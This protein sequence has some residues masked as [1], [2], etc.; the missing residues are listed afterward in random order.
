MT[1]GVDA[2]V[3]LL[4]WGGRVLVVRKRCPSPSPWACD[5]ALPGGRLRRGEDPVHAALREAW[6][7]AW[8]HPSTVEVK[9]IH[10]VFETATGWV[11]VAVVRGEVA[12]PLDPRPRDPEVDAVVWIPLSM[13]GDA[14][15]VRHPVRGQVYGILLPGGLI[16]W[17]VTYRILRSIVHP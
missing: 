7:E 15:P 16:L 4:E 14:G 11:R 2:S 6:E 8:V 1:S 13:V 3:L 9:G 10:G 17:G 5:T 12:G